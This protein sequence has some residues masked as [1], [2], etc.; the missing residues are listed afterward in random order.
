MK[1]VTVTKLDKVFKD[2]AR[3]FEVSITNGQDL[4]MQLHG[5]NMSVENVLNQLLVEM[6]GYKLYATIKITF[7]KQMDNGIII[8]SAYC[9]IANR[10]LSRKQQYS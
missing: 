1:P 9:S 10:K 2:A 6:K 3:S 8:K 7:K 5:S 4:L